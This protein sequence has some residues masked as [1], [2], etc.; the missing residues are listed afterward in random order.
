MTEPKW[1]S[2][3]IAVAIHGELI[4]EHGGL[5]GVRDEG[6]LES[7][8]ARANN[9][10]AYGEPSLYEVAAA[11]GFGL[12]RNHPFLDGNKRIALASIDVFLQLNGFALAAS[13]VETVAVI[14]DLAAGEID[15]EEL[16][17]W[18]EANASPIGD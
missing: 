10:H 6:L 11:Y 1:L 7:A 15:E 9:R 18:I 17:R 5:S 12:A 3:D 8:L 14:R 4:A 2:R 16:T 13:E